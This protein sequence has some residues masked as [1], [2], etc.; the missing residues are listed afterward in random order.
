MKLLKITD[1]LMI[2]LDY[3]TKIAKCKEEKIHE[4]QPYEIYLGL[5]G[6][7]DGY[8]IRYKKEKERDKQFDI[9]TEKIG[10]IEIE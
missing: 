4:R 7:H 5:E 6:H 1:E 9:L 10:I 8:T 3:I 2:N